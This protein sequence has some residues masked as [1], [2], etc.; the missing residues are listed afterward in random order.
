MKWVKRFLR[1]YA[2]G[3][4]ASA[5]LLPTIAATATA[6]L[7]IAQLNSE[8]HAPRTSFFGLVIALVLWLLLGI[9]CRRFARVDRA[10]PSTHG[11]LVEAFAWLEQRIRELHKDSEEKVHEAYKRLCSALRGKPEFPGVDVRWLLGTGYVDLWR[12][13]HGIQ[14]SL[15]TLEPEQYV[16]GD[17]LYDESRLQGSDIAGD[18]ELL[19]KLDVAVMTLN[20]DA[21]SYLSDQARQGRPIGARRHDDSPSD[22]Q[23]DEKEKQARGTLRHVRVT[24]ND[25]R[26]SRRGGLVRARNRLLA[27]VVVTGTTGYALLILA[28]LAGASRGEIAAAA[29]FFLVGALVGLFKEL[30]KA[31]VAETT[32]EDDFGFSFVR[33]LQIP[34]YSGLAALGGV[35]LTTLAP[36][37]IPGPSP[38]TNQIRPLS[39]IF[40][41]RGNAG[42]FVVAAVFGLSP[43]LLVTRL[44]KRVEEIK[45]DL[46]SS[47]AGEETRPRSG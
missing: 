31:A 44:Q 30:G 13:L 16:V 5:V 18:K 14:E 38:G 1:E 41:L 37:V 21:G 24:V 23:K 47:A 7:F 45:T 26:D 28:L 17:A 35:A 22:E 2:V 36:S 27:T 12:D 42:E 20:P 32:L 34:L 4:M 43:N 8:R 15:I 33:L 3:L 29:V 9:V 40:E 19:R 10:R 6:S 25:Y 11:E 39:K 46:K